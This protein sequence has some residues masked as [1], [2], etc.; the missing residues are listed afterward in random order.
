MEKE[1]PSPLER[2]LVVVH[3]LLGRCL[4]R[5]TIVTSS[6]KPRRN[7]ICQTVLASNLPGCSLAYGKLPLIT[8]KFSCCE[9]LRGA[10]HCYSRLVWS[11]NWRGQWLGSSPRWSWFITP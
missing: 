9:A 1:R 5:V 11:S 8:Q 10:W 4:V 6:K 7:L 2:T 3:K